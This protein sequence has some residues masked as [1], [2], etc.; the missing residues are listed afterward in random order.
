MVR[1][2]GKYKFISE[3]SNCKGTGTQINVT[4]LGPM[5]RVPLLSAFLCTATT[6]RKKRLSMVMGL[7]Q[8]WKAQTHG[9][10][11]LK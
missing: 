9:H 5:C 8:I 3:L 6:C 1:L 7:S 10:T 11:F 4:G 2:G